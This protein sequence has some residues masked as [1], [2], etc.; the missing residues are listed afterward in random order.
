MNRFRMAF[1]AAFVATVVAGTFLLSAFTVAAPDKA[2]MTKGEK[3]YKG[4]CMTC[5]QANGQGMSTIYP[6]LAKSDYLTK[7]SKSDVIRAVVFGLSGKMQV[8]GKN[9]NGVMTPL[10]G[11]YKNEDIAAVIT[12]VY[13]SWGN[14]GGT[15]TVKDVEAAKKLGKLK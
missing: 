1:G 5:H 2:V 15:V 4:Y 6:P 14:A 9:F 12:Y 13:N 11:N 7:K 10:P 3:V 8:N